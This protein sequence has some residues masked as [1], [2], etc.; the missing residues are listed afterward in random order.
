MSA[1]SLIKKIR[2]VEIIT[3][4]DKAKTFVLE[5]LDDW[6]VSY[7]SGQFLTLV[8]MTKS[9][10]KRRSYS[11]SSSSALN[12]PLSITV[13]KIDNGEFS[14]LLNYHAKVGDVLFTTGIAGFFVLPERP[15]DFD[16]YYFI[17]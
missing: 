10:E 7:K 4:T 5:P 8:F 16:E 1:D 14:R 13:K 3:E 2:I 17:A 9:G 6:K 11:I 12:E 15:E